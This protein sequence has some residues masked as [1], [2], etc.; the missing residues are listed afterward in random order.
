MFGKKNKIK[1]QETINPSELMDS[2]S[3]PEKDFSSLIRTMKKDLLRFEKKGVSGISFE[4]E[5]E[6]IKSDER[7]SII[8][9]ASPFFSQEI[10]AS[11]NDEINN[12]ENLFLK[13]KQDGIKEIIFD[14]PNST[15]NKPLVIDETL[16][17]VQKEQF[18]NKSS[19]V[20]TTA[21]KEIVSVLNTNEG[22]K[23]INTFSDKNIPAVDTTSPI[24]DEV[25]EEKL[26]IDTSIKKEESENDKVENDK[27]IE[28]EDLIRG[29]EQI[30]IS[31]PISNNVH[32]EEKILSRLPSAENEK[33]EE[34]DS[35]IKNSDEK[36]DSA[37]DFFQKSF[38]FSSHEGK[39]SSLESKEENSQEE[40]NKFLEKGVIPNG[41]VKMPLNT[42]EEKVFT[43]KNIPELP[44]T[45]S[46]PIEFKNENKEISF[47]EKNGDITEQQKEKI[48]N[49]FSSEDISKKEEVK[50]NPNENNF[51][52]IED[53]VVY[54]KERIHEDFFSP[55]ARKIFNFSFLFIFLILFFWGGYY[56][57][58]QYDGMSY[59]GLGVK[60]EEE[61]IKPPVSNEIPKEDPIIPPVVV[62]EKYNTNE[63]NI[64][65]SDKTTFNQEIEKIRENVEE[66]PVGNKF[67][68][69]FKDPSTKETFPIT[70]AFSTLANTI[71]LTKE[72][73][74]NL[75]A[76]HE[77]Y[78]V[79]F[80]LLI[81]FN[82]EK[83]LTENIKKN[84]EL[85]GALLVEDLYEDAVLLPSVY[86]FMSG[87]YN[88][89]PVRFHNIEK[90]SLN[91][92]FDYA[93]KDE[94]LAI[95]TSKESVR[96]VLDMIP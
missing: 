46:K 2:Q 42:K 17:R 83:L 66:L 3:K 79:R 71:D 18:S 47:T 84:L 10:G 85:S 49:Y 15:V 33:I 36:F 92:S 65:Q 67:K 28:T 94:M 20:T 8:K 51:P 75:V 22:E 27:N 57:W 72:A 32:I 11:G 81:D 96:V 31:T 68:F 7:D 90:G 45:E 43:E 78:G 34:N 87:S 55:F 13:K 5:K 77:S 89:I 41:D 88:S 1:D 16:S 60:K 19:V 35:Y 38:G 73:T 56:F 64:I 82:K 12:K 25:N 80:G 23:L 44:I 48:N 95:G 54:K 24:V 86:T 26:N 61:P 50:I 29:G 76:S 39:T 4:T 91:Y 70:E 14:S 53:K 37:E 21:S 74:W 59:L 40:K 9:E 93:F 52:K 62:A 63:I 6:K 58:I 30:I 69:E